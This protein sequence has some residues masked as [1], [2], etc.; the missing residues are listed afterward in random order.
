[1]RKVEFFFLREKGA[2][3]AMG[4]DRI[5]LVMKSRGKP[6]SGKKKRTLGEKGRVWGGGMVAYFPVSGV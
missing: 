6:T 4:E 1:V 3:H 5:L 2:G